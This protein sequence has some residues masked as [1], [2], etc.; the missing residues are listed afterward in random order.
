MGL[1]GI[2]MLLGIPFIASVVCI[3]FFP[4]KIKWWEILLIWAVSI[5]TIL[6][7][8]SASRISATKD[9][10]LWGFNGVKAYWDEPFQYWD[11]CTETYACGQTCSGTGSSRSCTTNYCTRTY[12]CKQWAG[13]DAFLID[14]KGNR[15]PINKNRFDFTVRRFQEHKY[16]EVELNREK[17]YDIIVD[18]DRWVVEWPGTWQTAEPIALHKTYKNKAQC[19]STIYF[20]KVSKDDIEFWKLI[21]YPNFSGGEYCRPTLLDGSGKTWE[22]DQYFRYINGIVGPARKCRLWV[23]IIRN[24][25]REAFQWQRDLWENGNKNEFIICIGADKDNNVHWGDVI[26]WTEVDALKIEFRDFIQDTMTRVTEESLVALAE[27]TEKN[28]MERYVK[29]DFTEKFDHL[30]IEPSPTAKWIS[31]IIV[32]L[33]CAGVCIFVIFNEYEE[34]TP[35]RRKKPTIN[36]PKLRRRVITPSKLSRG[37]KLRR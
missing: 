12:P 17:E 23:L 13:D 31:A 25:D 24:P 19:S 16:R 34:A 20:R 28:L 1:H 30:A 14:Q 5:F 37:K 21:E 27:F 33:V 3:V 10:E 26:S 9:H 11:T 22:A 8:Q 7:C 2:W 15:Y 4:R 32:L 36:R 18:G 29:P 6:I 35:S